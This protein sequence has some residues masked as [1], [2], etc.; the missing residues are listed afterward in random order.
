MIVRA[1]TRTWLSCTPTRQAIRNPSGRTSTAASSQ[2]SPSRSIAAKLP[3][4]SSVMKSAANAQAMIV[5]PY[6]LEA[7]PF[8][9]NV[10]STRPTDVVERISVVSQKSGASPAALRT[11]TETRPT[12]SV[13]AKTP[14]AAPS[15]EVRNE[16]SR[17]LPGFPGATRMRVSTSSPERNIRYAK[18]KAARNSS[19]SSCWITSSPAGPSNAPA[20]ISRT[21]A[22][23]SR[24]G[25]L[26]ARIGVRNAIADTIRSCSKEVSSI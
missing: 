16:R 19:I 23:T 21:T 6:G 20:M 1:T 25:S 17:P 12:T 14:R 18:P 5:C 10:G 26:E 4:S 13:P 8:S 15:G 3:I 11:A 22:G 7:R 2:L 24:P 9:F